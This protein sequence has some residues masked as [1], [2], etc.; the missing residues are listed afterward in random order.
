MRFFIV[1]F[2][3]LIQQTY[4][5]DNYYYDENKKITLVPLI[6][7]KRSISNVDYYKDN[8]G[9]V[10]GVMDTLLVKTIGN[11]DISNVLNEHNLELVKELSD[12]LYVLKTSNKNLTIYMSNTLQKNLNIK[13]AHPNFIKKRLNR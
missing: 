4:A 1:I 12:G 9:I 6:S 10:L 5:N 2:I 3:V 8:N 7:M 13:Y 11:Y